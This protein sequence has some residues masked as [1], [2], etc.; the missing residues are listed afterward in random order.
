M[1]LHCVLLV[2]LVKLYQTED[3]NYLV[4]LKTA[5]EALGVVAISDGVLF[6]RL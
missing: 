2:L 3:V 4:H 5:I 1:L 6:P